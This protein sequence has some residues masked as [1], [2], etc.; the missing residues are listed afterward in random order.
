VTATHTTLAMPADVLRIGTWPSLAIGEN[1]RHWAPSLLLSVAINLLLLSLLPSLLQPKTI[2]PEASPLQVRL[3]QPMPAMTELSP[4][5]PPART[6]EPPPSRIEAHPQQPSPPVIAPEPI[7]AST[8]ETAP[9]PILAAPTEEPLPTPEPVV[10]EDEPHP[11]PQ[12]LY[13]LTRLPELIAR[14]KPAYPENERASGREAE[15]LAEVFI[16][17]TGRVL[18]VAILKSAGQP[19]DQAVVSS[20]NESRFTPGYIGTEAVAVRLQIPFLFQ[21]D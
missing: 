4:S 1:I 15:V 14:R 20:L 5:T 3:T 10:A 7:P 18:D 16:D 19:F 12:P 6:P 11:T 21:L 9:P 17:I 2:T 8:V 13:K